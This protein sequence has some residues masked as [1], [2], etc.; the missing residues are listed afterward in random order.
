[1]LILFISLLIL[2][3]TPLFKFIPELLSEEST[4]D[5]TFTF[6]VDLALI[7]GQC[8]FILII[9]TIIRK[10]LMKDV[11]YFFK[12]LNKYQLKTII[13]KFRDKSLLF[14]FQYKWN[15]YIP[16]PE[17]QVS[18]TP[19]QLE[20]LLQFIKYI[21]RYPDELN[22]KSINKIQKNAFFLFNEI[23]MKYGNKIYGYLEEA[24]LFPGL[25]ISI[26]NQ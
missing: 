22:N 19:E 9:Y 11:N 10:D 20:E 25:P 14:S 8:F 7:I 13:C 21:K 12:N 2:F 24:R 17:I 6:T 1:M 15:R 5:F 3:I 23:L 4:M 26:P 18:F 16:E